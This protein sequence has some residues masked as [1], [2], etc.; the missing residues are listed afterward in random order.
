MEA[1]ILSDLNL[2]ESFFVD[3]D[4]LIQ[5][6]YICQNDSYL[7]TDTFKLLEKLY[8][9][10]SLND[11]PTII[12]VINGRIIHK[13]WVERGRVSRHNG[14]PADI[15]YDENGTIESNWYISGKC[16]NDYISFVCLKTKKDKDQINADDILFIKEYFS[17]K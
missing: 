1:K 8:K 4:L 9:K 12:I 6:G 3:E 7:D 10:K 5:W 16:I 2:N 17:I 13:I 14:K 15:L 11:E